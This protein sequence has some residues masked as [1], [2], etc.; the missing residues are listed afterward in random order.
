MAKH[1]K[2]IAENFLN[3]KL[4][5]FIGLDSEWLSYADGDAQSYTLVVAT[6]LEYYEDSG[7]IKL[8]NEKGKVFYMGEDFIK[9]FWEVDSGFRLNEST[10]STVHYGRPRNK[11]RDIV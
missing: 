11:T 9:M 5:L 1:G 2:F 4:E 10:T 6:P 3:H 7:M 8:I